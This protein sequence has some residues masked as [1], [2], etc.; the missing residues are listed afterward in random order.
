MGRVAEWWKRG[1]GEDAEADSGELEK[2][3]FVTQLISPFHLRTFPWVI[4]VPC[5]TYPPTV[6]HLLR[7]CSHVRGFRCSRISMDGAAGLFPIPV[8]KL[9]ILLFPFFILF[10]FQQQTGVRQGG[11]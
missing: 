8:C 4:V 5:W 1:N 10:P 3:M 11:V 7:V 2:T 9:L 6:C